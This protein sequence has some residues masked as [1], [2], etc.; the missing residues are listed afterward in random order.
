M[1]IHCIRLYF[2]FRCSEFVALWL[3]SFSPH[4]S[5]YRWRWQ[6]NQTSFFFRSEP[7]S[8][9]ISYLLHHSSF[10]SSSW[11]PLPPFCRRSRLSLLRGCRVFASSASS[12]GRLRFGS[13][14]LATSESRRSSHFYEKREREVPRR[15]CE[16]S[17]L[18]VASLQWENSTLVHCS[19]AN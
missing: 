15:G 19:T 18:G 14:R 1:I 3:C 7:S 17:T 13:T 5:Y 16:P 2:F 9:V 8:F 4:S 10:E 12:W 11:L 6:F